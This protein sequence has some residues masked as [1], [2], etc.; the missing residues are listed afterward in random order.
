MMSHPIRSH[1]SGDRHSLV[2]EEKKVLPGLPIDSGPIDFETAK[3]S[4]LAPDPDAALSEDERAR[5]VCSSFQ[6]KSSI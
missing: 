3:L 6:A 2:D 5:I 4:E 1:D